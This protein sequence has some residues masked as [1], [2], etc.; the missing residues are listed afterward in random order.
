M[1]NFDRVALKV[2]VWMGFTSL[3]RFILRQ[4]SEATVKTTSISESIIL[5]I[6]YYIHFSAFLWQEYSS[7]ANIALWT[8]VDI[9]SQPL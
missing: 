6:I 5:W 1:K 3:V 8:K 9:P 7:V 2:K 4:A